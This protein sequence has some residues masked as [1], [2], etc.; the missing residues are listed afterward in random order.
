MSGKVAEKPR[1]KQSPPKE[2]IE[3][4]T[5]LTEIRQ[6]F[7]GLDQ[8][9]FGYG[10]PVSLGVFRILVGFW[11]LANFCMLLPD[12]GD[13]FSNYGFVPQKA[14]HSYLAPVNLDFPAFG[15]DIHI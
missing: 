4:G 2:K 14:A 6:S 3:K 9:W 13:W 12:F 7:K 8:Y 15:R 11:A 1:P 5:F 10:S